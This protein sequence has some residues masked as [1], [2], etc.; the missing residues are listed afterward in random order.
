MWGKNETESEIKPIDLSIKTNIHYER[1]QF[2]IDEQD[3]I[4]AVLKLDS[5][6]IDEIIV[7][8]GAIIINWEKVI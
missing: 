2:Q 5:G 4:K 3:F 7:T 8:E 6:H 1:K